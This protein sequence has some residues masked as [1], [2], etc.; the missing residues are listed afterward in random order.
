MFFLAATSVTCLCI[1]ELYILNSTQECFKASWSTHK[2]VHSKAK[3][4]MLNSK[5]SGEQE[6]TTPYDWLYCLRK[7]QSRT[8][9]LP[10]FD[11]TGYVFSKVI[12]LDVV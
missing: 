12:T 10:R 9:K 2:S 3:M 8:P 1:D 4:S 7:G 6:S 11:W 5:I